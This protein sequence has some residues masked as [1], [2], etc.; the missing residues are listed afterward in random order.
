MDRFRVRTCMR[1]VIAIILLTM[2]M[3]AYAQDKIVVQLWDSAHSTKQELL[4]EVME[5]FK[6]T[7]PHVSFIYDVAPTAN[8][9]DRLSVAMSTDAG[10]DMFVL[11]DSLIPVYLEHDWLDPVPPNAFGYKDLNELLSD[12]VEGTLSGLMAG[13]KLYAM[14]YQYNAQSLIIN[15]Q[16]FIDAGLNP[17]TDYPVTWE[18]II[19]LNKRLTITDA[20]GR[21]LRKGFE[22]PYFGPVWSMWV[23]SALIRQY[24]GE[25]LDESGNPAIN[26]EAGVKALDTWKAVTVNPSVTTSSPANPYEDVFNEVV[27]MFIAPPNGVDLVLRHRPDVYS[28]CRVIP[29]PQVDP[30]NPVVTAYSF[31]FVV[32]SS[33][34]AE[35]K[36]LCWEYISMAYERTEEWAGRTAMF[37]PRKEFFASEYWANYD[38]SAAYSTDIERSRLTVRSSQWNQIA[39]IIDEAIQRTIFTGMPAKQSLDLAAEEMK[40]FIK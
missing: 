5:E 7:H 14:P 38:H 39:Q 32:N 11:I 25:I 17:K 3:T 35:K 26:S 22:M 10:P 6:E 33:T 31:A 2:G 23:F 30:A 40:L 28:N 16:H 15:E 29:F 19:R 4:R 1:L 13:E 20:N 18:D 12:H 8:L 21:I 36:K 34:T 37:S 24:G 27:S 9:W